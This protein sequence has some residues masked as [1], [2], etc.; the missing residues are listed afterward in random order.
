D[1]FLTHLRADTNTL[2]QND[3]AGNFTDA[4]ASL[5]LGPASWPYTGFGTAWLDADG[6]GFLDLFAANG[7]VVIIPEQAEAGDPHP[8]HQP[9]QLFHN[10]SGRG[11]ED[12]SGRAG[13]VF[14][15]SEVSRGAAVGD[16]D[17]DGDPDLLVC[18]N[19]GPVRLLIND[20][21]P[22]RWL[23][24]R[25]LLRDAPRDALGARVR[26]ELA[27]GSTWWRR[28]RADASFASANDPRVLFALPGDAPLRSVLVVW[29]GGAREAWS[30]LELDRYHTLR[31]GSGRPVEE[32]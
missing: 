21:P 13:K 10:L 15:L 25:A 29:P 6:D 31:Q 27:D 2:Y 20:S 30:D 8:L 14:E 1:V 3:G 19:D 11:F 32:P 26:V 12:F 24:V 4:T 22:R 18:N 9:N 28:V 5:G 16:V 23:G 17:D 7:E